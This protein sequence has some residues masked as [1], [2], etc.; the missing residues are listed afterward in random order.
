MSTS[1]VLDQHGRGDGVDQHGYLDDGDHVT[2]QHD[3][4]SMFILVPC[5]TVITFYIMFIC[6]LSGVVITCSVNTCA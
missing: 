1:G 6:Y 2:S 4:M 5:Y 3:D